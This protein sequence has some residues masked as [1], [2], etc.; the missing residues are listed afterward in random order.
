[1]SPENLIPILYMVV[2][3]LVM[4]LLIAIPLFPFCKVWSR[5]KT[6]HLDLWM[7]KGPFD[8]W[9]M[10]A[11]PE[12]VRG[13]L[14]IIALADKDETLMANDPYLVKWSRIAREVWKMAPRTFVMQVVYALAYLYFVWFFSST[15]VGLIARLI[16]P[17]SMTLQ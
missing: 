14:D 17:S 16:T 13:F 2:A 11:H 6:H 12:Y 4:V 10:M 9:E 3:A 15:I 8:L 5:L 1:M 7:A